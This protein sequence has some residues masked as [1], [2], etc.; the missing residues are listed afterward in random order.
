MY[1]KILFAGWIWS[2][3][4]T[5]VYLI[6]K[7]L[8]VNYHCLKNI[9]C[10]VKYFDRGTG[11]SSFVYSLVYI[12]KLN[13]CSAIFRFGLIRVHSRCKVGDKHSSFIVF[14]CFESV[15]GMKTSCYHRK[16]THSSI[17]KVCYNNIKKMWK[18]SY[19]KNE[20]YQTRV[21]KVPHKKRDMSIKASIS[22]VGYR[23][24]DASL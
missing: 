16:Y 8:W 18:D 19:N 12:Q 5:F 7:F 11:I 20:K 6:L 15:K 14:D 23:L 17:N 9:D 24:R 2:T 10:C 1:I 4:F 13:V 21:K 3:L 22:P